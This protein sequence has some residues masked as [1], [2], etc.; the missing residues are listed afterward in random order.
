MICHPGLPM[1]LDEHAI[2]QGY[3]IHRRT[4]ARCTPRRAAQFSLL[5]RVVRNGQPDY[6]TDEHAACTRQIEGV[7]GNGDVRALVYNI[8]PAR[9]F[10]IRKEMTIQSQTHIILAVDPQGQEHDGASP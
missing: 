1:S 10:E 5:V 8:W 4:A 7:G 9:V 6:R 3:P 2:H